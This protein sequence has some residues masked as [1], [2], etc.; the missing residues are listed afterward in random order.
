MY[1]TRKLV[2]NSVDHP[3][4]ILDVQNFV[5]RSDIPA[6]L[7]LRFLFQVRNKRRKA[8]DTLTTYLMMFATWKM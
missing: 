7:A 6:L 4:E 3:M 2:L 5:M 8:S 1:G